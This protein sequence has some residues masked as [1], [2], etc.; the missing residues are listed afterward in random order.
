MDKN[1]VNDSNITTQMVK[2]QNLDFVTMQRIATLF[3]TSTIVPD[4]FRTST[5]VP[6]EVAIANCFIALNMAQRMNADAFM[7]M[8]NMYIV[9]GKPS[10]SSTFLIATVNSCGRYKPLQ[11]SLDVKGEVEFGG[12][13]IPNLCCYAYTSLKGNEEILKGSEISIDLAIKENWYGKAGSKWQTMPEQMLRY[14]AATFW[15]RTYCPEIAMGLHTTD[16]ISDI[17]EVEYQEVPIKANNGE[18]LGFKDDDKNQT[19]SEIKGEGD[20]QQ[21]PQKNTRPSVFDSH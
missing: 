5:K 12:K 7:V 17:E 10:F 3:A 11:Y 9:Y 1:L 20:V 2:G 19:Y 16:E 13:K 8:Q 6:K 18:M 14:R 4:N 15:I 21:E